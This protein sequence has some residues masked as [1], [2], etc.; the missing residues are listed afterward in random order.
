MGIASNLWKLSFFCRIKKKSD[1][2][3]VIWNINNPYIFDDSCSFCWISSQKGVAST[4]IK[5]YKN[6]KFQFS[7]G[8][9]WKYLC[10]RKQT[11]IAERKIFTVRKSGT[12]NFLQSGSQWAKH[13]VE[14]SLSGAGALFDSSSSCRLIFAGRSGLCSGRKKRLTCS[15][16]LN[17]FTKTMA[18]EKVARKLHVFIVVWSACLQKLE[19]KLPRWSIA[20]LE[21]SVNWDYSII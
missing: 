7:N 13:L 2:R 1:T 15:S 4:G 17:A 5:Q 8:Y 19:Q 10:G 3:S 18:S 20:L 16:V 12:S 11:E 14:S 6:N 21:A 9:T